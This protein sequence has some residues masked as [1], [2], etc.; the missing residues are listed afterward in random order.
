MRVVVDRDTCRGHGICEA[1]VPE[2]FEVDADGK[3]TVVGDP[4]PDSERAA[5]Q[6]AIASC[7]SEALRALGGSAAAHIHLES[8]ESAE[9]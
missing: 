1:L 9:S 5:V 4:V 7:P 2:V 8:S 6:E 3:S